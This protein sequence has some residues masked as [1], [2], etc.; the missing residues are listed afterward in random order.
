[1]S[2]QTILDLVRPKP[3]AKW[4]VFYSLADGPEGGPSRTLPEGFVTRSDR[5]TTRPAQ[6]WR[7]TGMDN[8]P[9]L[10]FAPWLAARNRPA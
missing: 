2:L 10:E 5:D 7:L 4:V 8:A 1:M 6:H 3:E 9:T